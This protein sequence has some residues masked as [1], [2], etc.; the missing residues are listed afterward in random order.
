MMDILPENAQ[1]PPVSLERRGRILGIDYGRKRI[2][3]ALSDE[4]QLTAQP[5]AVLL[6]TNRQG[7]IRR[8]RDLCREHRVSQI[9]V[10]HPLHLTGAESEMSNEASRFATRLSKNLGVA[11]ELGEER[12]TS[13]DAEQTRGTARLSAR[14]SH[15]LDD[16]AA[17]LILRDYLE[18]RR[19]QTAP[20]NPSGDS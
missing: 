1:S 3:L 7:D 4:L 12:L 17:A 2:G 11:V 16:V 5:L 10:G 13:W 6:R 9:V 14:R 20:A 8:L 18:K 19:N 15:A